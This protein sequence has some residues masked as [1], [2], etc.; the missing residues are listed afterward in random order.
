MSILVQISV[1][2]QDLDNH[3]LI[4]KKALEKAGFTV[5]EIADW[6]IRKRSIDARQKKIKFN[7]QI[8]LWKEGEKCL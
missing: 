2:P 8:E 1:V 6:N 4:L 5:E 3:D 7:L